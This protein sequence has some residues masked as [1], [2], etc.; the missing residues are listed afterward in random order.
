MSTF[1]GE[2]S[3][4]HRYIAP[5][6]DDLRFRKLFD[7]TRSMAIQGYLPDGRVVYWNRAS[8]DLYG[9]SAEEALGA[10]LLDLI[11]PPEM[12]DGV[13]EAIAEMFA[14]GQGIPPGR[15][16]LLHKSGRR[17]PIYS[18]HSVVEV[19]GHPPVLFCMDSD[20]S[21]L[22]RAEA[23]IWAAK[24]EADRASLAK[25]KF[26]AAASH[27]LRQP[28]QTLLLVLASV[29]HQVAGQPKA[30]QAVEM[31][32]T[33]VDGLNGLLTGILDMSRLDAGV[34]TPLMEG[35]DLGGLVARLADE[36]SA[37]ARDKG[38][39]LRRVARPLRVRSD[40]SLLEQALR[41]LVE[42]ALRYTPAGGVLIG[43]RRR[44]DRAAI[45]VVDSGIGIPADKHSE[46]FEEFH[47]L[48]RPGR[49]R[50]QGL[51]LGL[52]I[53]ARVAGL[54]GAEVRLASQP[55]RGSRF[56][57]LLPLD[58][59]QPQAE[60]APQPVADCPGRLLVV[61][62]DDSL[63][64]SLEMMLADWGYRTVAVPTG[65]DALAV[66][67]ALDWSFDALLLDHRLGRG[68]T[69]TATARE[70]HRQSGRPFPTLVL[71]G[72]TAKERIAEIHDSGFA[73]LHKPI[74]PKVLRLRL[75]QLLRHQAQA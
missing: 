9:F 30:A 69:G 73:M 42:N 2:R 31:M 67:A 68:L 3:G 65:E 12:R 14:T 19:P 35:I 18:S 28:V 32:K 24:A 34:V 58:H 36:Y 49:D 74:A 7:E 50:G 44:G 55:G 1:I 21:A 27:D 15:L 72:D 6:L 52:A 57:L 64:N 16:D 38:L 54:L 56:S 20:M 61:E 40:S 11:I 66:A 60:A 48:D 41:N 23:E 29:E 75:A 71:T 46:I 26:L 5:E 25:S 10:N 13:R 4:S 22:T 39:R 59:E 62:D 8:E 43:V 53:V 33:A 63:R 51:G 70:M 47:Q 45:E 17:L 37:A